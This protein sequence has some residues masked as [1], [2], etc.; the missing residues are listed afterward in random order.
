MLSALVLIAAVSAAPA[1]AANCCPVVELRQYT[2][3]PERR[4]PFIRMFEREF[5]ET[6]EDVGMRVIGQYRDLDDPNHFVWLRG[7]PDM[8]QRA[9]SLQAFYGGPVWKAQ[10]DA[11]NANFTD[12]DNVLLLQA[13]KT[14]SQF[15]LDGRHRAPPGAD[16]DPRGVLI[17]TIYSFDAQPDAEFVA[18]FE[19][20][21]AP[22]LRANGTRVAGYFVSETEANSFPRLPVREKDHVFVWFALYPDLADYERRRA[23]LDGSRHWREAI[24]P[25]L[26]HRLL[27]PPQVLRLTPTPRA[28]LHG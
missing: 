24:A 7:F 28:L 27:A 4:D 15:A 11:A 20:Q 22:A 12:T 5:I 16:T 18:F 10:R 6:Q 19:K 17:A 14:S 23:S 21:I 8:P 26:R 9:Q 25:E 13:V 1:P 3:L 2:L